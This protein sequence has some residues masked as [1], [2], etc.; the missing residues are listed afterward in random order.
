[1][2]P[3]IYSILFLLLTSISVAQ[4]KEVLLKKSF[5]VDE[6]TIFNL[7]LDNANVHIIESKD[8]KIHFDYQITFYNYSKRKINDLLDD[9]SINAS[10][11]QNQ[12]FLK[13]KN[14]MYL[15]IDIK[16]KPNL[17]Y[18]N[19]NNPINDVY[20]DFLKKYYKTYR[21]S[22]KLHKTKDSLIEEI[23][24]SIG[25]DMD[26]YIKKEIDN[27]PLKKPLKTDKKIEKNFIIKVPKYV[28]LKIKALESD[29]KCDYDIS[30]EFKMDSFKGIFKFKRI[31]GKNNQITSS[32]GIL[33]TYG[34]KNTRIQLRDMYKVNIGSI[35]NS[36]LNL[37]KTKTQIGEIG[38]N[39]SIN[40][41]NSKLYL[42]NFS[43]N[44]TKFNLTGDYSTL[45]F[46]NI[47]ENNFSMDVSGFNTVLNMKGVKTT[48]G[49]SKEEK[50]TKIL[51]KKKK[52]NIPFLGNIEVE[53]KNGILNLK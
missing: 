10:K 45:N 44:F 28:Q 24:F 37:E 17:D 46:Y 39:V 36:N 53:L 49:T 34:I 32:N 50:I 42:Y 27:Y 52:E 1:M 38:K 19:F 2:K 12:I 25:R 13:V 9:T 51:E 15:G 47:K 33:E 16:Y 41:S 6:N 22:E 35:S 14:S 11:N 23:N 40:D 18:K 48:F 29:V 30:T 31:D 7:D 26:N 21:K 3:Y 20:K 8:D 5:K 4:T 43:E